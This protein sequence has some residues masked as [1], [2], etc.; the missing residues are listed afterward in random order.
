MD[1]AVYFYFN[2]TLKTLG[3]EHSIQMYVCIFPTKSQNN[4]EFVLIEVF[5]DYCKN[6]LELHSQVRNFEFIFI[7]GDKN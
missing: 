2:F 5:G 3:I 4:F 6:H 1:D 7:H